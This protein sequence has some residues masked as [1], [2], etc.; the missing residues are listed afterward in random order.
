MRERAAA[1]A[2]AEAL[3]VPGQLADAHQ[4]P[5]LD[6]L[7]A[8]FAQLEHLLPLYA[9]VQFCGVRDGRFCSS[10]TERPKGRYFV[11]RSQYLLEAVQL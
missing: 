7:P 3:L 9:R 4:V 8:T 2:A 10:G 1:H 6:L 5:V 11:I